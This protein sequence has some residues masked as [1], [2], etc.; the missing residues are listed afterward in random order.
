MADGAGTV[1]NSSDFDNKASKSVKYLEG[2]SET[3][4]IPHFFSG[5]TCSLAKTFGSVRIM[6]LVAT[7][8]FAA[9]PFVGMAL[10]FH[11]YWLGRM[12]S[13]CTGLGKISIFV[14]HSPVESPYSHDHYFY[15]FHNSA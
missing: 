5:R 11:F 4:S 12:V 7:G 14:I 8:S 9:L 3:I 10:Y 2:F 6:S 15:P 13:G 1:T